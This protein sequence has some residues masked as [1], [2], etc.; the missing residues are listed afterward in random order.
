MKKFVCLLLV[1]VLGMVL[2]SACGSAVDTGKT[3]MAEMEFTEENQTR[4]LKAVPPPEL[5]TSLERKSLK[6][7]L[8]DINKENSISYVYLI[9][10]GKILAFFTIKGKVTYCGSRLTTRQQV[11]Q[12]GGYT[13]KGEITRHVIESPGLDGSYGPSQNA[14]FFYTTEGVRITWNGKYLWLTEPLQIKTPVS[15]V[16]Q[17]K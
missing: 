14:V 10:Y 6:K 11:L 5:Q 1:P 3:T 8:E 15:L 16:R 17:V 4:L 2:L 13:S 12:V 9:D 7:Y